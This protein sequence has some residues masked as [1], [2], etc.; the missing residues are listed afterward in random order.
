MTAVRFLVGW[1]TIVAI[2]VS[3]IPWEL[4][5]FV[6]AG[7][8]VFTV[9]GELGEL[10]SCPDEDVP[11]DPCDDGCLCPCC[12][13]LV[14][15]LEVLSVPKFQPPAKTNPRVAYTRGLNPADVSFRVFHPPRST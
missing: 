3:S 4:A 1:I 10:P 2:F 9:A 5:T 11:C 7:D 12:P 14:V 8:D 15:P 13:T 6:T